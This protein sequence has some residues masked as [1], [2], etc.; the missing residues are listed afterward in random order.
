MEIE[1]RL[2]GGKGKGKHNGSGAKRAASDNFSRRRRII[3]PI[4]GS[5]TDSALAKERGPGSAVSKEH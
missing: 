3:V 4:S 1:R 5:L 2:R